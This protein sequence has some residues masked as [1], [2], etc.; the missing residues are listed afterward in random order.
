MS[1]KYTVF[2]AH[3]ANVSF[4]PSTRLENRGWGLRMKGMYKNASTKHHQP[5]PH[6][7]THMLTQ[8]WTHLLYQSK[9]LWN[10]E[11]QLVVV[12]LEL[13]ETARCNLLIAS[14]CPTCNKAAG[15][16]M[17]LHLAR[18]NLSV[19]QNCV[20]MSATDFNKYLSRDMQFVC[21]KCAKITRYEV[22]AHVYLPVCDTPG[23]CYITNWPHQYRK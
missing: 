7:P 3:E 1:H 22:Q 17:T 13:C 21:S 14:T 9:M 15:V 19:H 23:P 12:T 10:W 4:I 8:L 2:D 20:S 5:T 11:S 16:G 6:H 18:C